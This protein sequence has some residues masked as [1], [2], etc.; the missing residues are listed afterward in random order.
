MINT[1]IKEGEKIGELS[2]NDKSIDVSKDLPAALL[3]YLNTVGI[4]T[5]EGKDLN[6]S[7]DLEFLE[8]LPLFFS[9]YYLNAEKS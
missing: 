9:N 6:F 4:Y 5:R 3:E 7:N 1:F 8:A 2:W